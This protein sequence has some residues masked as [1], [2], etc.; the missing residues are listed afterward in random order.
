[1]VKPD[2]GLSSETEKLANTLIGKSFRFCGS[3]NP[4]KSA[5]PLIACPLD[6][7]LSGWCFTSPDA[8]TAFVIL[9]DELDAGALEGAPDDVE[10]AAMGARG[11]G[12]DLVHGHDPN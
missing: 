8:R 6:A 1:L 5:V 12:L 4:A 3:V 9:I 2:F 10:G 11:A 7:R